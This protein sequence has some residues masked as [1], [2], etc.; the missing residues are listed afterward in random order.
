MA[1][2][3]EF[4]DETSDREEPTLDQIDNAYAVGNGV[5]TEVARARVAVARFSE[6]DSLVEGSTLRNQAIELDA[7]LAEFP[8]SLIAMA[9]GLADKFERLTEDVYDSRVYHSLVPGAA[10]ITDAINTQF[11]NSEDITAK[12]ILIVPEVRSIDGEERFTS[13]EELQVV[14][15]ALRAK[16]GAQGK[17]DYKI[18]IGTEP[19]II[20]DGETQN[21]SFDAAA[22]KY[23]YGEITGASVYKPAEGSIPTA[24]INSINPA[25]LETQEVNIGIRNPKDMMVVTIASAREGGSLES[26]VG[27]LIP[28]NIRRELNIDLM[29]A[30]KEIAGADKDVYEVYNELIKAVISKD[31][32]K[33]S[34]TIADVKEGRMTR[35]DF[36]A[37]VERDYREMDSQALVDVANHIQR[38]RNTDSLYIVTS[39]DGTVVGKRVMSVDAAATKLNGGNIEDTVYAE[40]AGNVMVVP[41]AT[42]ASKRIIQEPPK[43]QIDYTANVDA[44][45]MNIGNTSNYT[46]EG[47]VDNN[48]M[49]GGYEPVRNF[50]GNTAYFNREITATP[51]EA[52]V[53]LTG[54]GSVHCYGVTHADDGDNKEHYFQLTGANA[55]SVIDTVVE[56][57][58]DS[59]E[60][61]DRLS[62]L[63]RQVFTSEEGVIQDNLFEELATLYVKKPGQEVQTYE[64]E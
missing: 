27:G 60:F 37:L 24:K 43:V 9:G 10:G 53:L 8:A 1:D 19:Y 15:D 64:L 7:Q 25:T 40:K 56:G 11:N 30:A 26:L 4:P 58:P 32:D 44:W 62:E 23:K 14:V 41:I 33:Y 61:K 46:Q 48:G 16:L 18:L 12:Q 63:S 38:T 36:D 54:D 17:S 59:R 29:Y 39:D 42:E 47:H 5:L 35:E 51:G 28:V 49:A 52:C 22:T 50:F 57:Y 34:Q 13:Q 31:E 21:V 3:D 2:G 6:L 55:H 45:R 20:R